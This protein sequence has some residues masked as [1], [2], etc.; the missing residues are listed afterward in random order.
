MEGALALNR[1][2]RKWGRSESTGRRWE[3][4]G[5][6][7]TFI[8]AGK[9]YVSAAAQREFEARALRGDF[10]RVPRRLETGGVGKI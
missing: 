6:L 5:W 8:I 9:K 1:W 10:A 2:L 7:R 3:Q 4:R